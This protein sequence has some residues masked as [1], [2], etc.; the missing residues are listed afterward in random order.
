MPTK[1]GMLVYPFC[2]FV[3]H[4][5]KVNSTITHSEAM[6]YLVGIPIEKKRISEIED[7]L[8]NIIGFNEEK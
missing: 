4:K 7:K 5:T 8:S 1:Q 2:D 6:V 3:C